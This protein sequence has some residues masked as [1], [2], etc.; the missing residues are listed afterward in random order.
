ME[1]IEGR[2]ESGLG[3]GAVF[4]SV[5]Y[6]KNKIKDNLGFEPYHGTL[7]L[8]VANESISKLKDKFRIEPFIWEGKKYGG[9]DCYKASIENIDCAVII[10]DLTEHKNIEHKNILEV[11]ASVNLKSKLNLA[12]GDKVK[13]ILS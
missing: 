2:I 11:V 6:Y 10:P 9:V 7:N 5:E 8:K 1:F 12:D 13:V 4:I 3:K